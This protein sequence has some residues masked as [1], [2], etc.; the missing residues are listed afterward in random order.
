MLVTW[1]KIWN[2]ERH[3]QTYEVHTHSCDV[4]SVL[5]LSVDFGK[6]IRLQKKECRRKREENMLQKKESTSEKKESRLEIKES[7]LETKESR[8]EKKESRR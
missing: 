2:S 1:F 3:S 5:P 8:T 6:E 4:L 7:R